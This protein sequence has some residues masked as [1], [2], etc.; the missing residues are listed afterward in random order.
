MDDRSTLENENLAYWTGRAPSYSDI[1]NAELAGENRIRWSTAIEKCVSKHFGNASH[2]DVRALDIG[3]GPGF[4]AIILAELGYDVT[5]VDMTPEMLNEARKNAG[6]LSD[7]IHFLQMNAEHLAFEDSSFNMVISRN[8]TWN[9]PHPE[10]AYREWCR[11]LAPDGILINFDSNWY[12]YLFDNDARAGYEADRRNC[13]ARGIEDQNVGEGFD[14]MERIA[15]EMPLSRADRPAWDIS[16]LSDLGMKVS[17]HENIWREV[18]S[19]QE[20]VSFAS[21][22]MFMIK[23]IKE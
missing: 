22:P 7:I 8:L 1:N 21:T 10:E 17:A 14:I 15:L 3:T 16:A 4:F 12:R 19:L 20:Q 13:A 9:L 11:V 18:W 6:E 2:S 5:A 23:A